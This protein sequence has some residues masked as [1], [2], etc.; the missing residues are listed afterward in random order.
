MTLVTINAPVIQF[1]RTP[2]N[3]DLPLPAYAT[4]GAAGFD[5]RACISKPVMI[6]PG[7][8]ILIPVG[9]CC[10]VPL[11]HELQ[12]RPRSGL[13]TKYGIT[14][15]NSPG[16][17]DSDYRGEISVCLINHGATHFEINRGARIA[18]AV[19]AP[20]VRATMAEVVELDMTVRGVGGFGSTGVVRSSVL[21][22]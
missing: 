12:I 5:L 8:R 9:F 7:G 11:G 13:A 17:A 6:G 18:Q 22:A 1:V 2:L 20:V 4:D 19:L 21:L 16:T 15:A 3:P 10:A 14:V